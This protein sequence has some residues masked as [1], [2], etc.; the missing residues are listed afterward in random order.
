MSGFFNLFKSKDN[1]REQENNTGELD[2]EKEVFLERTKEILSSLLSDLGF[3]GKVL[4]SFQ[5]NKIKL[6]IINVRDAGRIIGKEGRVI[7]AIQTLVRA[8]SFKNAPNNKYYISVDVENYFTKK[9]EKAKKVALSKSQLL[10]DEKPTISLGT[11]TAVERKAIHL[12]FEKKEN[13]KT[14]SNGKG[15]L[16]EI[17]IER[18]NTGDFQ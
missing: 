14:Y 13:F 3:E 17:F 2:K 8:I 10:T 15:E 5:A 9:V 4:A 12:V 7:E 6:D 1:I 11:K 18:L 16:K